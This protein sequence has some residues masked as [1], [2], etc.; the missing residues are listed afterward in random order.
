MARAMYVMCLNDGLVFES[1]GSAARWY[2]IPREQIGRC[3]RGLRQS[4][5]GLCFSQ[6]SADEARDRELC[7]GVRVCELWNRLK[8]KN[9]EG[10]SVQFISADAPMPV[11]E[12]EPEWGEFEP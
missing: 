10:L 2:Q 6:L 4:V 5:N 3:A 1:A 7:A 9:L 12:W 11:D 8:I